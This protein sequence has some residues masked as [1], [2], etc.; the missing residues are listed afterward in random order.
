MRGAGAP[1]FSA[2]DRFHSEIPA[3]RKRA[4]R[5]S[6]FGSSRGLIGNHRFCPR[7]GAGLVQVG[8]DAVQRCA[9]ESADRLAGDGPGQRDRAS[10]EDR[11]AV[12]RMA[13]RPGAPRSRADLRGCCSDV[14]RHAHLWS[15]LEKR[16]RAAELTLPGDPM[17]IDHGYRRNGTRGLVQ[18]L[19]VSR[20]P[21]DAKLLGKTAEPTTRDALPRNSPRLST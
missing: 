2:G 21:G 11:V 18:T 6:Q 8:R 4:S 17:R 5:Q 16:L 10:Y 15:R 19:S 12:P 9:I 3:R 14:F 20:S 13:R 7:W 1:P